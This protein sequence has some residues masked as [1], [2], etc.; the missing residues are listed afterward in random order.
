MIHI[1]IHNN[2][3]HM[4]KLCHFEPCL[5][6]PVGVRS[7]SG[8]GGKPPGA[9]DSASPVVVRPQPLSPTTPV[10]MASYNSWLALPAAAGSGGDAPV[11]GTTTGI[12]GKALPSQ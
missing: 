12:F 6:S 9:P 2:D 1:K 8:E 3:T 4:N 7:H 10:V 5:L 11:G